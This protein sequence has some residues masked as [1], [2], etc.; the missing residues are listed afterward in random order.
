MNTIEKVVD[1]E[2]AMAACSRQEASSTTGMASTV[3][4]LRKR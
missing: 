3:H 2:V 4:R 1:G